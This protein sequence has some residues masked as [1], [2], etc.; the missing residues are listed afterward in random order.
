LKEA[1]SA[2]V[3]SE[4]KIIDI[5]RCLRKLRYIEIG[6]IKIDI[7]DT[8]DGKQ[9]I[10]ILKDEHFST[11]QIRMRVVRHDFEVDDEQAIADRTD[12]L[13]IEVPK[14]QTIFV[15]I[16]EK[17][18]D[19]KGSVFPIY[20]GL[21]TSDTINAPLYIDAPFDLTAS[22]E[23]IKKNKWN[24]YIAVDVL[25]AV[26]KA[27]AEIAARERVGVLEYMPKD[28]NLYSGEFAQYV[29]ADFE[30]ALGRFRLLPTLD[31]EYFAAPFNNLVYYPNFVKLLL[32]RT[33]IPE[34]VAKKTIDFFATRD[35]STEST[36]RF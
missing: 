22:R 16:P 36:L 2:D 30:W 31:K 24:E 18:A 33:E 19:G 34:V 25:T 35:Y 27:L 21:P 11:K 14:N 7:K 29:D 28:G 15:Y 5:C 3:F 4:D 26:A 32:E 17:A 6:S 10:I 12:N 20:A 1:L 9:R 13:S 8:D 23:R